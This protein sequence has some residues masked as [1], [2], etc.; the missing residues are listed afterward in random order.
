MIAHAGGRRQLWRLLRAIEMTAPA[1][2]RFSHQRP[3]L[4]PPGALVYVLTSL[5]DDRAIE[6]GLIW[7]GNGHRVIAVDVL[8]TP[9]FARATRYE[10]IAHRIVMMEREDRIRVLHTGGIELLRWS[11]EGS[12]LPRQARLQL[13]S[14]SPRQGGREIGGRRR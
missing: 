13:L 1:A 11:E 6:L 10:R 12:P 7:R 3:P 5:L 4:V 2:D 14:R 9:R 8:P